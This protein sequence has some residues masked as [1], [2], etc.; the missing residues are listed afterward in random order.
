MV[1]IKALRK[2]TPKFIR[3]GAVRGKVDGSK[4]KKPTG[5]AGRRKKV[6]SHKKGASPKIGYGI[7][8]KAKHKHTSGMPI[9]MIANPKEIDNVDPKSQVI[10]IRNVG[11]K[12]KIEIVEKAMSKNIK[13]VNVRKPEEYLKNNKK[14]KKE[15]VKKET[16]KEDSKKKNISLEKKA[17]PKKE[18]KKEE[19][20]EVKKE[21]KK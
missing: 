13:I 14:E 2:K 17:L 21:V 6:L 4:W 20:T 7:S 3:L 9:I 16:K 12:K 18:I 1:N 19:K 10:K 15:E 11:Q 5:K 8:K